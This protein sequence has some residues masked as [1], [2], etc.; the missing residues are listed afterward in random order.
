MRMQFAGHLFLFIGLW[1]HISKIRS[2][3][4][5]YLPAGDRGHNQNFRN[6]ARVSWKYFPAG[7]LGMYS[8]LRSNLHE[9]ISQEGH[10]GCKMRVRVTNFT[11]LATVD[12][13]LVLISGCV[14]NYSDQ[15]DLASNFL[16]VL[17]IEFDF[18]GS[19]GRA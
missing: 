13:P 11:S 6:L 2:S 14:D 7:S 16:M 17:C 15:V 1:D 4:Q 3:W 18:S 8:C 12:F 9:H 19:V 10:L 5:S